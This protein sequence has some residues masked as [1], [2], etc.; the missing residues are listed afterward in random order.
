[1]KKN[2][3]TPHILF[4]I[5]TFCFFTSSLSAQLSG[6]DAYMK[7]NYVEIGISGLG[8]FEGAGL[9]RQPV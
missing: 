7:G 4:A 8:G 2:S 5:G 9:P 6:A 3:I 1:M